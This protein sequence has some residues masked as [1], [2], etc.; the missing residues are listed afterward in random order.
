MYLD[1]CFS[2]PNQKYSTSGKNDIKFKR[3]QGETFGKMKH[4]IIYCFNMTS[5]SLT[6]H[7]D[8][9]RGYDPLI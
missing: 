2:I 1:E 3:K 9:S 4:V 8:L 6:K 7:F 5:F